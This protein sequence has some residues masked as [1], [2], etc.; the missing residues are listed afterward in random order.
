MF[1]NKLNSYVISE[2]IKSY[3]TVLFALSLLIWIAQAAKF[4]GLI[5]ET[6][7]SVKIYIT[8]IFLIF[9]KTLSQLILISF[10]ISLFMTILKLQENKELDIYNLSG[11]SKIE[12]SLLIFKISIFPTILGLLFYLY[13]VPTSNYKSRQVLAKSEF[14][15]VNS[16]VKKQNFNSSLKNLTIFVGENDNKG[17]IE[18]VYIFEEFKTIIS[19]TGRVLNIEGKN[20]LE[21]T[22]GFIHEKDKNNKINVVRFKKTMFDFTKYQTDII[23]DPKLQEQKTTEIIKQY[24]IIKNKKEIENLKYELH[25]R[26][27]KPLFIPAIALICCFLLFSNNEKINLNKLKI[28]IFTFSTIFI[29]FIEIILN[30]SA[31]KILYTYFLYFLPIILILTIS[32]ILIKFLNSE[33]NK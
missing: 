9:P 30:F 16:L 24:K 2:V 26:I 20:Y 13:I 6:G 33:P 18:K 27:F 11:I 3:L 28:S 22:D 7:L 23:K 17:N 15:M 21:L 1:K 12:I 4:L 29:I 25:K 14:S 5:T 19:K 8:Y 10:L 31:K 32:I